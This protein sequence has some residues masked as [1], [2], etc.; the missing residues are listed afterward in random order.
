MK[1]G[2]WI[3]LFTLVCQ[4]LQA[5]LPSDGFSREV[6]SPLEQRLTQW[7]VEEHPAIQPAARFL[8][9]SFYE[10]ADSSYAVRR[11]SSGIRVRP[12]A[13]ISTGGSYSRD[14][15]P[16]AFGSAGVTMDWNH[17]ERWTGSLGYAITGGLMPDYYERFISGNGVI[18]GWNYAVHNQDRLYHAH[19]P[20][21][22]VGYK[23][24]K[25]FHFEV[26]NGK[27]FWGDGRRSLILSDVAA[28]YPYL[29][30]DTKV[31][32]VK[33][34]NLFARMDDI[35][36]GQDWSE[37]RGK[38]VAL[39]GLSWNLGKDVNLTLFE[40]VVWQNTDSMST[41][42]L[43]LHYLNPV[44]FY[45]PVEYAQGS[46]DNV[47][48]GAGLRVK[49]VK[50]VQFYTQLVIDEFL[51]NEVFSDRGW[52][53]NKF[54][55]Q[56][57]MKWFDVFT[58]GFH[59]QLEGNVVRPF[60]YTHGSP[61]QAWGH[62]RQPLAHPYGANFYEFMGLIRY[63][64]KGWTF[65]EQATWGSFG[66]DQPGLNQGGDIFRSYRSPATNFGNQLLQGSR[67][68]FHYHNLTASHRIGQNTGWEFFISHVLRHERGR[69]VVQNDH[70][71]LVGIRSSGILRNQ[72]DF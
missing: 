4:S 39:H 47:L 70:L 65:I 68:I 43:D 42:G 54:G 63:E 32:H 14:F 48:I 38:Y 33:Y 24:G 27:H 10:L 29:R 8:E 46:A 41:R 69:G 34:T 35:L 19:V 67:H 3:L 18:P 6:L 49:A 50:N 23:A 57:G 20:F 37:R 59:L 40:M 56:L 13:D 52:W 9:T 21:G 61:V 58:K 1:P 66:R 15:A 16:V 5:Q 55:G 44:I 26:G 62:L 25:Y 53:A 11:Y 7:G 17:K 51:R 45:R 22:H 28:P 31:W 71:L 2:N 12:I 36:P 72:I 64:W 30:I 60:T